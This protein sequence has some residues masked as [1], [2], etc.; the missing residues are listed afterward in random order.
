[1][2]SQSML[3]TISACA[4]ISMPGLYLHYSHCKNKTKLNRNDNNISYCKFCDNFA[5]SNKHTIGLNILYFENIISNTV[6]YKH[7]LV[8]LSK[9]EEKIKLLLIWIIA[10]TNEHLENE[11][12]NFRIDIPNDEECLRIGKML[13]ELIQIPKLLK[14]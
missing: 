10:I 3:S 13:T 7:L 9:N 4:L 5:K 8:F 2:E 14:F 11:N 12:Y 1:M 6:L